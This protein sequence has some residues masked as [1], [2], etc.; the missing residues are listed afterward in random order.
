MEQ[1]AGLSLPPQGGSEGPSF[2]TQT[3]PITRRP[4][5]YLLIGLFSL[6]GTHAPAKSSDSRLT[7]AAGP[8]HR[9][10][11]RGG[12]RAPVRIIAGQTHD[13]DSASALITARRFQRDAG[14]VLETPCGDTICSLLSPRQG[15]VQGRVK[16]VLQASELRGCRQGRA[17]ARSQYGRAVRRVEP[18]GQSDLA[19]GRRSRYPLLQGGRPGLQT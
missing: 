7:P 6:F 14:V 17:A 18:P 8:S 9:G 1:E 12:A 16:L 15:L 13:S 11:S 10:S 19:P 2:I 3:A 5:T 4:I